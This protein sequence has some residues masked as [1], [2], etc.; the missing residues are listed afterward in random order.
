MMRI[1][2][3][4]I[5]EITWD[6]QSQNWSASDWE[7]DFETMAQIGIDTVVLIRGGLNKRTL[8]PTKLFDNKFCPDLAKLFLDLAHTHGI[9][10]FFG[11][12]DSGEFFGRKVTPDSE[13]KINKLFIQEVMERYGDH[14][15]LYG[16]YICQ[17]P[18]GDQPGIKEYFS[19]IASFL[20][21]LKPHAPILISPCFPSIDKRPLVEFRESWLKILKETEGFIDYIAFQDGTCPSIEMLGPYL[22]AAS[23][24]CKEMNVG[25]W[26]NAETFQR[27]LSW[28]FPP[29]DYRLLFDKLAIASKYVSKIITFEFSHF[30]SPNSDFPS[31]RKLY[32]L[33][34][35]HIM[36][37]EPLI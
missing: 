30:M 3:A 8:F 18:Y 20:K 21:Q 36:N 24:F 35:K 17:E 28:N 33:Y 13:F 19:M 29:V 9:K 5:D 10:L 14:P 6:I 25:L 11:T 34:I 27:G 1:S 15:A 4:F 32:Q 2:G 31:A 12:Y 16:W 37:R 26:S 23:E 22:K 7:K